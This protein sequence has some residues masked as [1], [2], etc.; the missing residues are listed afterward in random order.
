[1]RRALSGRALQ[2]NLSLDFHTRLRLPS[3]RV[4]YYMCFSTLH[5]IALFPMIYIKNL[6]LKNAR[7]YCRVSRNLPQYHLYQFDISYSESIAIFIWTLHEIC[8]VRVK[9]PRIVK[10]LKK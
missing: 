1:M 4:V 6:I 9:I 10:L 2:S 5:P 7:I 8:C 3:I